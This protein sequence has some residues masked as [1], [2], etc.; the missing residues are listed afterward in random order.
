M[1]NFCKL[2]RMLRDSAKSCAVM[3]KAAWTLRSTLYCE[4]Y[5]AEECMS[6]LSDHLGNGEMPIHNLFHEPVEIYQDHVI[7]CIADFYAG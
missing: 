1:G 3:S 7:T 2:A 5:C 4:V 6:A